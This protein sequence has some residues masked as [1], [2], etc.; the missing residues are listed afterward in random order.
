MSKKK[1]IVNIFHYCI[2]AAAILMS[3]PSIAFAAQPGLDLVYNGSGVHTRT[4]DATNPFTALGHWI[5]VVD[6]DGIADD[7]SSHTVTVTY[8]NGGPTYELWFVEKRDDSS[9]IYEYW[10]DTLPQ[11]IDPVT[12]SGI[13]TYRVEDPNG[14]WSEATDDLR[15]NILSPPDE[16]TFSPGFSTPRSIIAH[17]DDVYK[18]GVLYDDFESGFDPAKWEPQRDEVVSHETQTVAP[19]AI[20]IDGDASDWASLNPALVDPKG[21]SSGGSGADLMYIYTAMDNTYAYVMV[22]THNKPISP[23]AGIEIYFNYKPWQHQTHGHHDDLGVNIGTSTLNA[24][25]DNDLDGDSEPYPI[26]G[27]TVVRGNVLEARIPLS[28]IENAA[29]FNPTFVNIW[30]AGAP[31]HGDDPSE[32]TETITGV[33]HIERAWFPESGS[34]WMEMTN[35]EEVTEHSAT[36]WVTDISGSEFVW[37]RIGGIYCRDSRGNVGARVGIRED[38]AYISVWS[39]YW[40][41]DYHLIY[42]YIFFDDDLSDPPDNVMIVSGRKYKL[43]IKWDEPTATLTFKILDIE[44]A[45][46]FERSV[47]IPGSISAPDNPVRGIG[48]TSWLTFDTTTPTFNWQ[49]VP[50]ANH[51]SVRIYGYNENYDF[52]LIYQGYPKSPPYTL[53]PGIIK[54]DGEYRLRIYAL[55][56]HQWFEWENVSNSDWDSTRF[57]AGPNEAQD[58]YIDLA[59]SGVH[60]WTH[61]PPY[62]SSTWFYIR[63]HDAQRVPD[64]IESVKVLLPD[65]LTEVTLYLDEIESPT[66]GI[67]RGA[68]FG[69]IQPGQYRFIVVDKDGFTDTKTEVL[70]SNP[71][72]YPPEDSLHPPRNTVIGGTGANFGWNPVPQAAF[73]QI[74]LYDKDFNYL[75]NA[76]TTE[77]QY[78]LPPGLLKENS[79]YRY[80]VDTRREFREDNEDNGSTSPGFGTEFSNTFFTTAT[81]GSSYPDLN[82][83]NFGVAVSSAPPRD[84]GEPTVY[85]LEFTAMVT[86]P[87]GVPENIERVEVVYPDGSTT[88]LL[89]F[90]NSPSWGFNY[91]DYELYTDASSIPSGTFTFRTVDFEGNEVILEDELP[92][93]ASNALPWVTN[94]Y[95]S[96]GTIVY[97]TTPTIKWDSTP[98]AD[99]YKVRIMSAYRYPTVHWSDKLFATTAYT[100]PDGILESDKTYGYRIYAY[101]ESVDGEVDFYSSHRHWHVNNDHF[102]IQVSDTGPIIDSFGADTTSGPAP[103]TVEFSCAAHDPNGSIAEYRWD[104][105]GDGTIDETTSSGLVNHTYAASETYLA[106][107]TV[108][109]SEGALATSNPITIVIFID[110][111]SDGMPDDWENEHGL[112]PY[113]DDAGG[114]LDGDGLSNLAE[115]LAATDPNNPDTDSDGVRDGADAFTLDPYESA[116]SDGDGIGDNADLDDDNDNHNAIADGG[117]DCDDLNPTI[118]PDANELPNNGIDEDC[119]GIDPDTLAPFTE[120]ME[121]PSGASNVAVST[122]IIA[123][124]KDTSSGV[125]QSTIVMRVQGSP[126]G[127]TPVGSPADYTLTYN[128]PADFGNEQQ[129]E[130]RIEAADL[131]GNA[132]EPQTYSFITEASAGD[133]WE[134]PPED[135]DDDEDG[136]PNRLETDLLGTNP[137]AKTLFVRPKQIEGTAFVYWPGF[138][139]LFPDARAGFADIEAFTHA[140][141]EVSVIGDAGHP[142]APMRAFN[143]DPAADANQPPCDILEIIHMA[144]NLHC[145][146]GGHNDG[147]TYFY[148]LGTTWFWDTK[149]YVPN[150]QVSDHFREHGYFTPYIYPFPLDNYLIEGAYREIAEGQEPVV[151]PGCGLNQCYDS[152]YSSPLNL[153]D[154]ESAAPYIGYPD[155][156]VEF[157]E[158]VFD[159][160]MQIIHVGGRGIRYTRDEVMRR[161]IAHEMGHA[162][163]AAS[164]KDHCTDVKCIMYHSVADWEMRDFGPGDCV[165]KPGGSKDI[166]AKGVV[167]NS[168]H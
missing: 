133:P 134:P 136:I 140:G 1:N 135:R 42:D 89:K 101:K 48:V 37:A 131:S 32:V 85:W 4:F 94:A 87:E 96:D 59:S 29:Y 125:D 102:T 112:D 168:I 118:H 126:V 113:D 128:P 106:F 63:I 8:P 160:N 149:G 58:P 22:E 164:E 15:V 143:Y 137:N 53:P 91:Y 130:V 51:Y 14:D 34:V 12:Y 6:Y 144:D 2:L 109:D 114:D 43:T 100:I 77:N 90:D 110:T 167:H 35:P 46:E 52:N 84:T 151:D 132:M 152:S 161:T 111:D 81:Y 119:D 121:P 138:I 99:Y 62:D 75:F 3:A 36:V 5:K 103:L 31:E 24:W 163:L 44:A 88:R 105:D 86:D 10:D 157:N 65:A 17:F 148:N 159:S 155:G 154:G 66:S 139:A 64:N 69:A 142:Y 166:R 23:D 108:E 123:H 92:D 124:V 129:V 26:S 40:D 56:D 104:Y 57:S 127:V 116:D 79:L 41:G 20:T 33:V 147:H 67:Y 30:T 115:Y 107:V 156:T 27:Y 39:E 13:Y 54:P 141:I 45:T 122:N 146:F 83:E 7:G 50:G 47:T 117:N 153:D 120:M 97:T 49:T 38:K 93:V 61:P 78:T 72:S 19:G 71:I 145:A 82:I 80:K 28:E 21:D 162:L 25:N 165:H 68:Y 16:R 74:T 98:E 73:Y 55:R 95:P 60:T 9:A 150:N 70:T 158:I 18:N 11:P 76:K